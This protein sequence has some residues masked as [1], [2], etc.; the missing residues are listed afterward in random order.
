MIMNL[1]RIHEDMGSIPGP[2]QWVKVWHALSCSVG[3]R[4]GSD[5]VVLWLWH[6]L[7][8]A[9]PIRPLAWQLPFA[10]AAALE[11]INKNKNNLIVRKTYLTDFLT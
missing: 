5:L 4:C 7:A 2:A 8:A 3:H 10:V 11:K 9:A 1:T 6:R